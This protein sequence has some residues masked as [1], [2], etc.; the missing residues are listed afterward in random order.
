M[1]EWVC[2]TA[3]LKLVKLLKHLKGNKTY[4]VATTVFV[5]GGLEALGF[6]IPKELYVLLG[7][8]GLYSLRDAIK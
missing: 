1:L 6:A 3:N 7:S 2:L 5:L 8:L 4:L